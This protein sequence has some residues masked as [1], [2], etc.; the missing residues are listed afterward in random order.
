MQKPALDNRGIR[1]RI[2]LFTDQF[3]VGISGQTTSVMLLYN[4]FKQ[5]GHTCY[6]F[7]SHTKKLVDD[8]PDIIN[9]PG[10]PYPMKNMKEYR[11]SPFVKR[12][13]KLIVSCKLD[14]IHVHTEHYLANVALAAKK[15]LGV[16]VVYTLHTMWEYYLDYLSKPI[17]KVAHESLWRVVRLGVF[18]K[19]A[20]GA[21]MIVV[22]SKKLYNRRRRYCLGD[23]MVVIP[24]GIDLERFS[25]AT[26]SKRTDD[27]TV[28]LY[29]G[30]L[31]PEK[32]IDVSLRAFA[33]MKNRE[34]ARFVIV[35]DGPATNDLKQLAENLN[36][37]DR[38]VFTGEVPREETIAYYHSADAFISASKTESQG[39]TFLEALASRLPI[40]AI[41][42]EVIEELVE[43][44]KN[45]FL[46]DS[47]AELTKR[48]EQLCDTKEAPSQF[49]PLEGYSVQDYARNIFALYEKVIKNAKK[50]AVKK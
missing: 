37:T 47:E 27:K 7:T 32:S 4:Y 23:N 31:S 36:I 20:R 48:M 44:G 12:H 26:E 46:C 6:I 29:V 14:I 11:F 16:P 21:D 45:G 38:T 18:P 41:R 19:M 1:M 25:N 50:E 8:N 34:N 22:P 13:M 9:L 5:N 2:G 40:Y 24:T 43:D 42:D 39:L 3:S 17:N 30:R 33:K 10:I 35:G 28:F 15:K 49:E